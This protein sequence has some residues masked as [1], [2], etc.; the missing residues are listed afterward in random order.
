MRWA[1]VALTLA[2]GTAW[3]AGC[4]SA[5]PACADWVT[6]G[7]GDARAGVYRSHSLD[8]KNEAITRALVMIHGY[9][10]NAESYFRTAIAAASRAGALENTVIV[11][12]RFTSSQGACRDSLAPQ[13]L[14]WMC[15]GP[16]GWRNGGGAI[17]NAA[18]TSFHVGDAIVQRLARKEIFPNLKSIVVAG[19]SAGG[20]YAARYAMSNELHEG[21]RISMTYV[22]AN[23]SSYT[24]PDDRR[25]ATV[26]QDC[27]TFDNW[28]YGLQRRGGYSEKYSNEQLIR[29]LLG[30]STTFLVGE[31]DVLPQYNFDASCP[32]M[33]Q[34]PTRLARGLAYVKHIGG[35]FGAKHRAIVIPACGHSARC[36]FTAEQALPVLFP[37]Q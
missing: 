15:S 30:R 13:E 31:L 1:S 20:Q 28:P 22:V 23:P 14:N 16:D 25:P 18:I 9:G 12:P 11:A 17:G 29:Q 7:G 24:Y 33:A 34:G 6:V 26:S 2:S 35:N 8:A 10:R 27:P 5:T 21:V 4:T 3:A 32:A 36:M 19:H 37:S